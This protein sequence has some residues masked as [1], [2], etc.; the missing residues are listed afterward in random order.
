MDSPSSAHLSSLEPMNDEKFSFRKVQLMLKQF[1]INSFFEVV[2]VS[3]FFK[4]LSQI[5][6][7]INSFNRKCSFYE[8]P[9]YTFNF[10]KIFWLDRSVRLVNI[11]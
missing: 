6:P 4:I 7:Q 3:N 10:N 11:S 8:S 2:N 5:I 9:F 1:Q